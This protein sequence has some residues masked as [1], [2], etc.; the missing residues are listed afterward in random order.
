MF[1]IKIWI[2]FYFKL[3]FLVFLLFLFDYVKNKFKK[4]K[5][6]YIYIKYT[7]KNNINNVWK[8]FLKSY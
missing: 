6:I 8:Y 3:V 5:N 4:L 2:F 7:L 1:F